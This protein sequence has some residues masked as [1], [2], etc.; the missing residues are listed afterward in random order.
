MMFFG[1]YTIFRWFP[2]KLKIGT[3]YAEHF[4]WFC[5]GEETQ[6]FGGWQCF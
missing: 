2:Q 5:F 1:F 3:L 4:M 6:L